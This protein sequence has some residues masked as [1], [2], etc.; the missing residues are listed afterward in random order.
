M[1]TW[2]AAVLAVLALAAF[3][4]LTVGAALGAALFMRGGMRS[5]RRRQDD[6]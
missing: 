3:V 6:E 1:D 4:L 5:R 2:A